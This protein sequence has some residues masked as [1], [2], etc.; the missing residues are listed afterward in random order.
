L[1]LTIG[2]EAKLIRALDGFRKKR[3]VSNYDAEGSVS[4]RE[5][6]EIQKIA[7]RLRDDVRAWLTK[8]HSHLL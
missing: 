4:D 6:K 5:A 3:H 1:E 7:A 8:N 2:A